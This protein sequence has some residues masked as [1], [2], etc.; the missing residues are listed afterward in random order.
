MACGPQLIRDQA[1]ISGLKARENSL[2]GLDME[3][4]G[5][6]L[7][8]A[9]CST[10]AQSIIPLIV[11]GVCDFADADK[12]D[13]WHDYCSYASASFVLAVCKKIMTLDYPYSI[14]RGDNV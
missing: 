2:I 4:Y 12:S 13:A 14:L 1:Y 10:H 9:M 8:A 7:A 5:V 6:A 3:S 11:K